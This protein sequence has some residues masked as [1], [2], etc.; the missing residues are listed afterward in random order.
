MN[1]HFLVGSASVPALQ[2][3][4]YKRRLP[5]WRNQGSTYFVTWRVSRRQPELAPSERDIVLDS[6]THF[7]GDRYD[8]FAYVVMNDHVHGI[9]MPYPDRR[10][11]DIMHS[12]KSFSAMKLQRASGREGAIWQREYF[13]RV[14]R[15]EAEFNDTVAYILANPAKRWPGLDGYKW[16]GWAGTEA[17]PTR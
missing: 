5:H 10:L 3:A 2:N 8:L 12:W 14:I 7:H 13:N 1:Q 11:Q 16:V 15:H 6:M 9:V 17:D 4:D